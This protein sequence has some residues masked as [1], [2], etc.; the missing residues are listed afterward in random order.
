MKNVVVIGAGVA[1]ANVARELVKSSQ[2]PQTHRIVLVERNE[3][4]YWTIGALRASVQPGFEEK[5]VGDIENIFPASSRHVVLKG[6]EVV[7]LLAYSIRLAQPTKQFPD[8]IVEFDQAILATGAV[9]N[10]P[11]RP[12]SSTLAGVKADFKRLQSDISAAHSILI[13]GGGPV[14]VEL[15]GEINYV[16]PGKR[17]TLVAKS[18]KL[19]PSQDNAKL[20]NKLL[21]QL[22][23]AGNTVLTNEQIELPKEL[24]IAQ[25]LPRMTTFVTLKGTQITADLVID[26]V[27]SKPLSSLAKQVD[28]RVTDAHNYVRV[29]TD[30]RV[31]SDILGKY[32]AIGDLNDVKGSKT[33]ININGQIPVA[34]NTVLAAVNPKVK[35]S[36]KPVP[37]PL[38]VIAVPLGPKGGAAALPF[39]TLGEWTTS[40]I[41][42]KTLLFDKFAALYGN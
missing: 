39:A 27:G 34:V 15:A 38:N 32:V 40:F 37:A 18:S 13:V 30:L 22:Q 35:R 8:A 4:A 7:Q 6:V 21:S 42:G 20:H 14:G 24:A 12:K 29:G 26:A 16:H 36:G 5:A 17:V 19:I 9:Y 1:G 10:F 31:Q 33:F 23:R 28:E 11:S 25:L 3:F 2:F 41:K